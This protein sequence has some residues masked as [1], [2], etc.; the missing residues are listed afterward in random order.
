MIRASYSRA[1]ALPAALL[2][3][4]TLPGPGAQTSMARYSSEILVSILG[5]S[6]WPHVFMKCFTAR[7]ANNSSKIS[8]PMSSRSKYGWD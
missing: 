2:V 8:S 1:A 4:L 3:L 5:M 7:S 6:M